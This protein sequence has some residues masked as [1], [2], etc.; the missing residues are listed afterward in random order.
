MSIPPPRL[1][2]TPPATPYTYRRDLEPRELLPAVGVAVGVGLAA[3]YAVY[4][5]LQRTPLDISGTGRD[6]L[7]RGP[8]DG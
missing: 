8:I 5:L 4:V 1:R 3:F 2:E 6:H 7:S